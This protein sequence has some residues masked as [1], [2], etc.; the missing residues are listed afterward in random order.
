MN[1][2]F[3]LRRLFEIGGIFA[4]A[5]LIALGVTTLV[6]GFNGRSTVQHSLKQEQIVGSPDMT[7]AEIAPG[8]TQIKAAQQKLAAAQAKAGIPQDQRFVFT[9]VKAPSCSAAGKLVT[10]G[11][12]ARC[13]AQYMRIHALE[14][15]NGLTYAQMGRFTAKPGAPIAQT[16]FNGGTSNDQFAL[17]DPKTTQ[18]VTNHVR[19]LWVTETALTTALNT[20]Y[21]A[22]K[23]SLFGLMV[24][25]TL[26]LSGFGFAIL[27]I[28]GALRRVPRTV[29]EPSERRVPTPAP[30]T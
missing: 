25:I 17:I 10:N 4:G 19:D 21:M 24:G 6:M 11:D 28:G 22:E 1:R 16:D 14:A 23:I 20:S 3:T 26:L 7:P 12:N 15:T 29:S 8:V 18:P 9:E 30:T 13:F 27:A 5:V 2:Q